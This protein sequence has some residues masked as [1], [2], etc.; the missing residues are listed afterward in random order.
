[1]VVEEFDNPVMFLETIG[2]CHLVSLD[3]SVKGPLI[4]GGVKWMIIFQKQQKRGAPLC[5]RFRADLIYFFGVPKRCL[6]G[7]L[8]EFNDV[9]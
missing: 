4:A 8:G 9:N 7:R 6:I 3:W 5:F 1:M 2:S